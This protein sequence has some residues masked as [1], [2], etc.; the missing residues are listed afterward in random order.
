M[1]WL[2][3]SLFNILNYLSSLIN[4]S[5]MNSLVVTESN[6]IFDVLFI[7]TTTIQAV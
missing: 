3:R 2:I 7:C 1:R 4:H 5:F 6:R